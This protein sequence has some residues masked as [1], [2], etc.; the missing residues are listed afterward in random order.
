MPSSSRNEPCSMLASASGMTRRRR[1]TRTGC[2]RRG[3]SAARVYA[4]LSCCPAARS[5]TRGSPLPTNGPS[6]HGSALP[7]HSSPAAHQ[8]AAALAADRP[9]ARRLRR[10]GRRGDRRRRPALT[11]VDEKAG[12]ARFR[13]TPPARQGRPPWRRR[14]TAGTHSAGLGQNGDD[15]DR[16]QRHL[17]EVSPRTGPVRQLSYAF[18]SYLAGAADAGEGSPARRDRLGRSGVRP[19][20]GPSPCWAAAQPSAG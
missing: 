4:D 16:R 7:W 1:Q 18:T 20:R 11:K 3:F 13:R 8:T 5:R 19:L 9:L 17:P 6:W 15:A 14:A 10:R 12:S 2:A